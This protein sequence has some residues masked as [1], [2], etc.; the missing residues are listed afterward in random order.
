MKK[1]ILVIMIMLIL[2]SQAMA[3]TSEVI[4]NFAL[5][6]GK[7]LSQTNS[8]FFFSPF[9]IISAFSMAYAGA[10][11]E[12]SKEITEKLGLTP[13]IH[14][15]LGEFVNEIQ[16]SGQIL[17]A[18]RIW[19]A[20]DLNINENYK[21]DLFL[22]YHSDAKKLD[23]AKKTEASRKTINEWVSKKTNGK[24]NDLLAKLEP[25]TRMIITNAVYF[26]A[27]WVNAFDKKSTDTEKFYDGEKISKVPMMKQHEEFYYAEIDGNK[28][29]KLPYKGRNFSMVVIL[30]AKENNSLIDNLDNN[31]LNQWLNML[32]RYEVDLWIPKFKVEK[33]YE[34]KSL[35]ES[36]GVKLAFSDFAEFPGIT[37]SEDLKIDSV[38]HKT[39]IDVD[40]EK[41][42]AAAAT[43]LIM[44]RTTA[45]PHQVLRSE[46]H[47][48]RP[49]IYFIVDDYSD[50]ILFMGRQTF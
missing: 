29:I 9:S 16:K 30:P 41:T 43:A 35:F 45:V 5:N 24:I 50:T 7:I 13:E 37:K 11:G 12:T 10:Y 47:A 34:L 26:N 27:E 1:I 46:F 40:E 17:S 38:I 31:L 49:F 2:S 44:V 8:Q 6:A 20:E 28:I 19:L 22:Y 23:F 36:L 42:E 15:E 4:N 18:N 14:K 32:M 25:I 3:S 39:F 48:D 33:S 21:N